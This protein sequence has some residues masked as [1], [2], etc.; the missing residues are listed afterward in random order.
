MIISLSAD[1]GIVKHV[2]SF[3]VCGKVNGVN[4]F[5]KQLNI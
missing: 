4:N 3:I 2:L 1:K 5:E